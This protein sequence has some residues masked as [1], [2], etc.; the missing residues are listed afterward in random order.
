[1]YSRKEAAQLREMFWTSFGQYMSPIQS[2]E[3]LKINWVNYKTGLKN[4]QFKLIANNTSA[5]IAIEISASDLNLQ[6]TLFKN[7][8]ELKTLFHDTVSSSWTWNHGIFDES[9]RLVSRIQT[10]IEAV[11]I[12][13]KSDWPVLISFFKKH[14]IELD[15]FWNQAKFA[16]DV[17]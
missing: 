6:D 5:Y 3:G 2:S 11:N 8:F 9:Q 4:L 17:Y 15:A 16:F 12:L 7:L 13:N 10:S 14:L 1:M